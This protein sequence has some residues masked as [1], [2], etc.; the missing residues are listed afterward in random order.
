MRTIDDPVAMATI[1][2]LPASEGGRASGPPT[3]PVYVSTCR[4]VLAAGSYSETMSVLLEIAEA[5][6]SNLYVYVCKVDFLA[7]DLAAPYLSIG[8]IIQVLE[9]CHVEEHDRCEPMCRSRPGGRADPVTERDHAGLMIRLMRQSHFE[10]RDAPTAPRDRCRGP[11]LPS[12]S[13][14]AGVMGRSWYD[15]PG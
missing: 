6:P 13:R 10:I 3:A 14:K 5:A 11:D 4:F 2:W 7:H 8:A 9:Q 1:S 15:P 12:W